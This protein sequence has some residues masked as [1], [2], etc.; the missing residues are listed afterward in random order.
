MDYVKVKLKSDVEINSVISLHY[1]E[2]AKDFSYSG[3]IHDFWEIVYADKQS[4]YIT[5]GS[6]EL[7]L[8][9]GHLYLHRP[10]EFHKIRCDGIRAANSVIVSFDCDCPEL[11]RAAGT[12]IS[13]SSEVKTLLGAIIREAEQAF[14]TP[15]GLAYTREMRLSGKGA[16]GCEQLIRLY[17]EQLLILLIRGTPKQQPRTKHESNA[18]LVAVSEYLEKRVNEP[19]RF[20][21]IRA[22][23]N[24][25]P[26]VLKKAFRDHMGCGAME[27]FTRLKVDAA[28]ERIRQG[29]LNITQIADSLAFNTPQY[30]CTVFHRIT[31]MSPTEYAGSVRSSGDN[32]KS[33]V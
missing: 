5:A 17:L 24:V 7:L 12:V 14:S 25:S 11:Y 20:S 2:Y 18:L 15:L 4:I 21:D 32:G 29:D 28:K 8:P 16:F 3:E 19:L 31:G 22:H 26:S 10:N 9:I 6:E 23:F 27:Y 30:F 13:A 33:K 1:F